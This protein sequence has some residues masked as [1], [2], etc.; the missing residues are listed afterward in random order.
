LNVTVSEEQHGMLLELGDLQHRSAASFLRELL[1]TATP[2]LRATLP[3]LRA[4]SLAIEDQ[5]AALEK[6]VT[7]ALGALLGDD[8]AQIDLVDHIAAL[9]ASQGDQEGAEGE[10][11]PDARASARPEA[12]SP[13]APSSARHVGERI[14]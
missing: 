2:I 9:L 13:V 5:P 11:E 8:P 7:D 3:I 6:S 10:A 12:D 1:D 4:R 14:G